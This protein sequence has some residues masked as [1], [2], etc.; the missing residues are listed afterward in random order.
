M[1]PL[2]SF[3][4]LLIMVVGQ[5]DAQSAIAIFKPQYSGDEH[6][7]FATG[8]TKED[9]EAKAKNDLTV[10]VN[11]KV[12]SGTSASVGKKY[13]YAS[14]NKNGGYAIGRGKD[15]I[16]N[17][18]HYE[19]ILA[20]E[21]EDAAKKNVLDRISR[22]GL[23]NGEI[24]YSGYDNGNTQANGQ[25]KY[26]YVTLTQGGNYSDCS[27]ITYSNIFEL[28]GDNIKLSEDEIVKAF[29]KYTTTKTNE[30]LI[31]VLA[32]RGGASA[33]LF[34]SFQEAQI[35]MNAQID[36]NKSDEYLK[37]WNFKTRFIEGFSIINTNT[38]SQKQQTEA[39][40]SVSSNVVNNASHSKNTTKLSPT[41]TF[42]NGLNYYNQK[43][44]TEAFNLFK[45][46]TD[47]GNMDALNKIVYM[48][49]FG[50][51]NLSGEQQLTWY[52]KAAERD[53]GTAQ[54]TLGY[55]Y[56][57]GKNVSQSYKLA[58]YWYDKAVLNNNHCT[59]GLGNMYFYGK[60]VQQS[61]SDAFHWYSNA[62]G[63]CS[64]HEQ[65]LNLAY[66]YEY[67][68]GTEKNIQKAKDYYQFIVD[69]PNQGT[70][71]QVESAKKGLERIDRM[72]SNAQEKISK[73]DIL[74]TWSY[75]ITWPSDANLKDVTGIMKIK[76]DEDDQGLI[77]ITS[78]FNPNQRFSKGYV[79]KGAAMAN[80]AILYRIKTDVPDIEQ[81]YFLNIISKTQ[82]KGTIKNIRLKP[83]PERPEA[84]DIPAEIEL[85]K[86][87]N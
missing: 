77:T 2:F 6:Y 51:I 28:R 41:E 43:K 37:F 26:C 59:I 23:Y 44:Y 24:V 34:N 85:M 61:Y 3:L 16:G 38:I 20:A 27:F 66:M 17:F 45:K 82:M 74:G 5:I 68:K 33:Q 4:F 48:M 87:A 31:E 46:A 53:I 49:N 63:N 11:E 57:N 76:N 50:Q 70:Y 47:Q 42:N 18:W 69:Y 75:V 56:Y 65:C 13:I 81:Q 9:A 12:P 62:L 55:F 10:V 25:I 39:K 32:S 7:G 80:N 72:K 58:K 73:E 78:T 14:T 15:Q 29:F 84:W 40:T 30:C 79:F 60:G 67:G 35:S 83:M 52:K 1:K 71:A 54:E 21:S 36:R 22:R 19:A 86:S 64:N 8:R